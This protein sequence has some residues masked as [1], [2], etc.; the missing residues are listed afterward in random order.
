[1]S[2]VQDTVLQTSADLQQRL[3]AAL[4]REAAL[5]EVLEV[6]NR[7]P[8]DPAPVFEAILSKAHSL[9]DAAVGSLLSYDGTHLRAVA[10]HGFP[11]QHAALVRRPFHPDTH[12]RQLIEG[13]RLLHLRDM[14]A[15][16][17]RPDD[18]VERDTVERTDVRTGLIV[19]LRK[20]RTF[21]GCISAFRL[22]VRPFSESE[23]ALLESFAAQAVIAIESA[24]LLTEQREA[25]EQQTATAEVL[26][27]I[28]GS[29]GNLEPVFTAILDK[30]HTI[31]GAE[32]GSLQIWDGTHTRAVGT[33]GYPDEIDA[34]LRRPFLPWPA[35]SRLIAGGRVSHIHDLLAA[36][37]SDEQVGPGFLS[38]SGIRTN[39]TVP[40]RKDGTL[41]GFITANRRV[42]RPFTDKE[43]ALLENFGTQAVIAMENAR[44]ISDLRQRTSDLQESLEYQTATSDVLKVISRSVFDLGSVL[45]TALASAVQLCR[46]DRAILYRYRDGLCQFEVGYNNQ[47]EYEAFERNNPI[48]AGSDTVVGRTMQERQAVQILD[49]LDDPKYRP[50]DQAKINSARSMLGV[51]L[52]RDGTLIGVF[53]LARTVVEPFT[54]RQIEL[55][56][57][58]ADQAVIAI[59]NARL[60]NELQARTDELAQRQ[61]EL[62]ITFENMG[63]GV[64]MFDKDQRLVA[65]NQKCTEMFG[66]PDDL[67]EQHLSIAEYVRFLTVRGDYGP[68]ADP[69]EQLRRITDDAAVQHPY[70]RTR[71]DGRVIEI[72]RNPV[73][74]GG[75]VMIFSDITERKRSESEI[76][77]ARDAAEAA[78]RELKATQANLI[79]AEKMAS[80]GQLTAG[81]AHEI[82]NPLNFVNNFALLSVELLDDVKQA[83]APAL[84]M[85]DQEMR[86]EIDEA[87]GLLTG[88]LEKITE[89][90]RRADGIVRSM[91][92]HSR[93]ETGERRSVELNALV[94]EALNLAYHGARAQ[95][96]SFNIALERDLAPAIPPIEL[97]P[98]DITRVLLNLFANGFYA[99]HRRRQEG[100]DP[101]FQ[102]TLKVTT[103][104]L[105]DAVEIGVRD[106]GIGIPM[107]IRERLFQPFFT[108]KPTGE[109]TGL[110]LSI[111]YDIVTQEHGGSITVDSRV[112]EFSEFTVRLPRNRR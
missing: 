49:A 97:V 37:N 14:Q 72:R 91:L 90:G 82:K 36:E 48:A 11:N 89:H 81:I 58:F 111:S 41:L 44:L 62:R 104:D 108:T 85:L 112:G 27:V 76:R 65:W 71:P 31:C 16:E 99:A 61:S 30:A 67:L 35:Q 95:D 20:G 10:T 68:D 3:D 26:R 64:A 66:V 59:E 51:P 53:A 69:E 40:L 21:F 80:L 70:E 110:G 45:Q 86:G 83:V 78:Y 84:P 1:M 15:L 60:L 54:E 5:A 103:R 57:T 46:A 23:I 73:P 98:Q 25:L 42:V 13:E 106:N 52:L 2:A 9:C 47:H 88:N 8:G 29:L 32:M 79:Q 77:A 22:E 33:H 39:L 100:P 19:P 56:T 87:V 12:F 7:S 96:K 93:S 4:A 34:M 74:D 24:R 107:E 18:A 28:N 43:I 6:I 63:D 109:G 94:E 75:F 92:E 17:V 55:V 105:G 102:P 101:G 38:G 50:K